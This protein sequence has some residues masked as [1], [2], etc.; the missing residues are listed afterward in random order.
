MSATDKRGETPYDASHPYNSEIEL[1]L[2]DI[3][4]AELEEKTKKYDDLMKLVDGGKL[5]GKILFV[6]GGAVIFFAGIANTIWLWVRDHI[7]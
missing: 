1:R 7:R 5:A 4:L 6:L 3:R 2:F